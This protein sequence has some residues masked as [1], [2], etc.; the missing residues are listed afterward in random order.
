MPALSRRAEKDLAALPDALRA[1]AQAII[2]RLDAEPGIGKKLLGPLKGIRSAR[3][4]RSH[5]IL[6]E[7]RPDGK[8]YVL[9]V[10]MRRDVYR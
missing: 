10:A 9:T 7:T 1:K 2:A 8:A 5:R 4:G 6:Y 3:L